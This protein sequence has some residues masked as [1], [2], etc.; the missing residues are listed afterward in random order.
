MAKGTTVDL[1]EY[2]VTLK[3]KVRQVMRFHGFQARFDPEAGDDQVLSYRYAYLWAAAFTTNCTDPDWS[4]PPDAA[5]AEELEANFLAWLDL[6][7]DDQSADW[8]VAIQAMRRSTASAEEKP[9]AELSE[10]E[11]ADPN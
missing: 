3:H 11:Q 10:A 2:Q 9:E 5:T 7:D 1:G 4:P 6:V 8:Y